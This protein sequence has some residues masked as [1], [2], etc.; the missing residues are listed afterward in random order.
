MEKTITT[1]ESHASAGHDTHVVVFNI[2]LE[3]TLRI[4][5]INKQFTAVQKSTT[6]LIFVALSTSVLDK[7]M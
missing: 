6:M 1:L 2:E 4:L 7:K 5:L 3:C